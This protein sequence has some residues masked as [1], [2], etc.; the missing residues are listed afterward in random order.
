[1]H[2]VQLLQATGLD[3][4]IADEVA[5]ADYEDELL[6]YKDEAAALDFSD[7]DNVD[8]AMDKLSGT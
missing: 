7:Q 2:H 4:F 6:Q 3:D 8:W 5:D 1:M